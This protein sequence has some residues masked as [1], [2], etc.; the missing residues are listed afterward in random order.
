VL[1]LLTTNNSAV[2]RQLGARGFQRLEVK[3]KVATSAEELI[4]LARRERPALVILDVELPDMD[5]Y[6]ACRRLKADPALAGLRVMLVLGSVLSRADLARLRESGCDDVFC[7]PA[8]ADELYQH[9][10]QLLGFPSRASRRVGVQL[11]VQ[12]ESGARLLEGRLLNLSRTGAKIAL[13]EP[14]RAREVSLRIARSERERPAVTRARVVWEKEAA[15]GDGGGFVLGVQFVDVP[16]RAQQMVD[17]LA[18]WDF[19]TGDDGALMVT[20]QGDFTE[21]TDFSELWRQL[22]AAQRPVELDLSR[23]RYLNSWGVRNW[24]AFLEGLP[25]YLEYAFVR[26]SVALVA[27]AGMVPRVLGRGR[28]LSFYAP[29]HCERCDRSEERLLQ[30]ASV[31]AS[32]P[33]E[34]PRFHC[35]VCDGP[36]TFDDLADR[37]FS[38]LGR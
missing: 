8:P 21:T 26:A 19:W 23:V 15:E 13:F 33:Y 5:G 4:E 34:P 9:V 36:L 30:S 14:T 10:S 6:E 12:V 7:V 22:S 2:F 3:C 17:A 25:P 28:M 38:F 37:Y 32:R 24:V 35:T 20:L 1:T 11:K 31:G 18:L 16:A 27:Q 29:Y